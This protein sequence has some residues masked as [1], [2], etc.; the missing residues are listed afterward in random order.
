[1]CV[2]TATK[3][4]VPSCRMVLLKSYG[5]PTPEDMRLDPD[6]KPGFVFFTNYDSRKGGELDE[7]P[8]CAIM[9]YWESLKRSVRIEGTALKTSQAYS[10]AY[11]K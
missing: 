7:N 1:M 11:F 8:A 9:F 10:E 5:A 4:G 3:S 2:A 6:A